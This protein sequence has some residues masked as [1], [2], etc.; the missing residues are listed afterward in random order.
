VTILKMVDR[1][2]RRKYQL[3]KHRIPA[4][5]QI[6]FLLC[7]KH[8]AIVFDFTNSWQQGGKSWCEAKS[9][10][11]ITLMFHKISCTPN[12]GAGYENCPGVQQAKGDDAFVKR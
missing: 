1:L 9:A 8:L 6:L 2:E 7:P 3:G 5:Y 4:P 10:R 11:K 12:P